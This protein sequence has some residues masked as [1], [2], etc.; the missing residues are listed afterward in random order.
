[1]TDTEVLVWC[2]EHLTGFREV[3][4]C[5]SWKEFIMEWIDSEGRAR[6]TAGHSLKNAVEIANE[7]CG[8][9]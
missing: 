3:V 1:M 5:G 2:Q 9:N 6:S 4:N 7:V 8:G